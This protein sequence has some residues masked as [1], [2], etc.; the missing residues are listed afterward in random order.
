MAG[1]FLAEA[2][3]DDCNGGAIMPTPRSITTPP[4][5]LPKGVTGTTTV[6]SV[7]SAH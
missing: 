7:A 6:V 5:I 2:G 3:G 1:R 4:S